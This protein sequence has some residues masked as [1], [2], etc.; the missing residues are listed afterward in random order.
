[1][2]SLSL[3]CLSVPL[4]GAAGIRQ[5]LVPW[6]LKAG[7]NVVEVMIWTPLD[8]YENEIAYVEWVALP[9][10]KELHESST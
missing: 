2:R 7:L 5:D 10:R 4:H 1:M 8:N 3:L 9:G 6:S